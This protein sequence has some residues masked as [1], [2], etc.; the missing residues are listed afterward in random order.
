MV[1]GLAI[2]AAIRTAAAAAAKT[3][4][5]VLKS[6]YGKVGILGGSIG[7]AGLGIGSGIKEAQES[8]ERGGQGL[9][10]MAGVGLAAL[11]VLFLLF[12]RR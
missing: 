9:V 12:R 11:L 2:S 7:W 3:A 5:K 6:P 10:V 1:W 8:A 4:P